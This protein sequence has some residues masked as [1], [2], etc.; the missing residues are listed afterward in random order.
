MN[1]SSCR[2]VEL[3]VQGQKVR[4]QSSWGRESRGGCDLRCLSCPDGPPQLTSWAWRPGTGT[5]HPLLRGRNPTMGPEG[6]EAL[7]VSGGR[8]QQDLPRHW[9]AGPVS[10]MCLQRR[11]L[12]SG[13]LSIHLLQEAGSLR[14]R[15]QQIWCVVRTG[16]LFSLSSHDRLPGVS[17]IRSLIPSWVPPSRLN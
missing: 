2:C 7:Q 4:A 16:F 8:Q 14:C 17:F 5:D 10:G 11:C 12:G 6:V 9:P 15:H 13:G 3:R 1:G